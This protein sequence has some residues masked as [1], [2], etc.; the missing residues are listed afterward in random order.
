MA[1]PLVRSVVRKANQK[2]MERLAAE[3]AKVSSAAA[4]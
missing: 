2:A 1:A 3:L 4:A